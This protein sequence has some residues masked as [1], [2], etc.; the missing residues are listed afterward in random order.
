MTSQSPQPPSDADR[1]IAAQRD[2][3]RKTRNLLLWIFIGLPA[4]GLIIW[5]CVALAG[6]V[7]THAAN[8]LSN[9]DPCSAYS[10]AIQHESNEVQT[11]DDS[12]SMDGDQETNLILECVD[13]PDESLGEAVSA[14][15]SPSWTD[16]EGAPAVAAPLTT[17]TPTTDTI[18]DSTPC[19]VVMSSATDA[20]IGA[21]TGGW[22]SYQTPFQR[23]CGAHPDELAGAALA[24]VRSDP[25]WAPEPTN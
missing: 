19:G 20:A 8:T 6:A 5:G 9:D 12:T 4:L 1:I 3:G 14:V 25:A 16:P 18:T 22:N 21:Y 2:E 24:K 13:K 10:A 11:F 7:A 23:E 15:E 17:I